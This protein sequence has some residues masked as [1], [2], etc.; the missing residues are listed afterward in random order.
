[1]LGFFTMLFYNIVFMLV[2]T[3]IVASLTLMERKVLSLVQRRVGPNF[4]GYKGRLQYLADALKLLAKNVLIP[5][6]VNKF[7]FIFCPALAGAV[8]YSFWIN[9]VWGPSLSVFDIEYNI[10]YASLLS[11]LFGLCII[12]TGYFSKNK[13]AAMASV[14][15]GLLMLNLEIFLG[16]VFLNIVLF[17]ESFSF[18][19]YVTYQEALWFI[20]AFF[21]F[22]A[23]LLLVFLL[24]V[25]RTPFD[26]AEAESELVTGYSTEYGG[27]YFALFYLGEYF[28]L[29][30]FS[31]VMSTLFFG[32]WEWPSVL[33]FFTSPYLLY[34]S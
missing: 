16:L 24:E 30:F 34:L 5:S 22:S 3:L 8:C 18:S 12:L 15:C 23:A 2:A 11:V 27:F 17:G 33:V 26:L 4:V 25:N 1:M 6:E 28:H 9:S 7:W 13:Y 32:G 31:V 10:V 19:S 21:N 14:R 20:Y 29:F